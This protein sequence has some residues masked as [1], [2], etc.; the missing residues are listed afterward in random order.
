M[1]KEVLNENKFSKIGKHLSALVEASKV[2]ENKISQMDLKIER[3]QKDLDYIKIQKLV[4]VDSPCNLYIMDN[5][6]KYDGIEEYIARAAKDFIESYGVRPTKISIVAE[7]HVG[8]V[9]KAT[10]RPLHYI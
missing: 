7:S 10:A 6:K 1:R 2:N 9:T 5:R 3:L 4:V 8:D